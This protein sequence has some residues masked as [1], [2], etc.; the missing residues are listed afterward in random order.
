MRDGGRGTE[1]ES[2]SEARESGLGSGEHDGS[3]RPSF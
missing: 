3:F 2:E 1:R